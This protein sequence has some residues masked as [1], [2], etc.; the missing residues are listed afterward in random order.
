[1]KL[2]MKSKSKVA[3]KPKV[4]TQHLSELPKDGL[5]GD[6]VFH[7]I[8][9]KLYINFQGSWIRVVPDA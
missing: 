3:D 1:M 4:I 7:T 5:H 2:T 8:E 6:V 9:R